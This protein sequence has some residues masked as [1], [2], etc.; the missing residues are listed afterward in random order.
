MMAFNRPDELPEVLQPVTLRLERTNGPVLL[1]PTRVLDLESDPGVVRVVVACPPGC[2]PTEHHFDATL[3]WTEPTGRISRAVVAHPGRR[4]Y[5]AVWVLS[6]DGPAIRAQ[7]RRHFRAHVAVPARMSWEEPTGTDDLEERHCDAVT[8]DI[9]EGG[10]LAL[11]RAIPPEIDSVVD[12]VL[13]I[14]G[15]ELHGPATVVRHVPYPGGVGVGVTFP[16]RHANADRL[17]RAAFE[18]ERRRVNRGVR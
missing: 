12:T 1:A 16:D 5:G 13:L 2:D 9:S 10:V 18:A 6:T 7:E 4:R 14:D 11:V 17:R 15:R 3:T 8:I